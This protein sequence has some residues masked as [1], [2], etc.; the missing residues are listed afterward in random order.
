MIPIMLLLSIFLG[1]CQGYIKEKEFLRTYLIEVKQTKRYELI[2]INLKDSLYSWADNN[3][4]LAKNYKSNKY[5]WKIDGVVFNSI[6]TRFFGWILKK[7]FYEKAK[8]D[9]VK[10]FI[11]E[12]QDNQWQFYLTNMP[13]MSI[14][15]ASTFDYL[16]SKE[17][18]T[19]FTFHELSE[20][21]I[22]EA[23]RGGLIKKNDCEINNDY[24]NDWFDDQLNEYHQEYLND[25]IQE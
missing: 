19:P 8:L 14:A 15:R 12:K 20:I 22:H 17:K 9:Y 25:T 16:N 1:S 6:G 13:S 11:A 24:I 23:V 4:R 5:K 18:N 10:Y 3:V 21:A 2:S 7:D